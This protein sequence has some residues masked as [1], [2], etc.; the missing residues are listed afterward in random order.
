M[1]VDLVPSESLKRA[2]Q[3]WWLLALVMTAGG[4]LGLL[5]TRLHRPLYESQ[6]VI[7]TSIDYAYSGRLTDTEED[8]IVSTVGDLV[9]SS[10]VME[11][12]LRSAEKRGILLT[13]GEIANRFFK[14]R[15]GFRWELS[16]R[17]GDPRQAQIL[18]GLW[19]ESAMRELVLLRDRSLDWL[20]FQT[21]QL[22]LEHC[23]SQMVVL[24]PAS[25]PC[26][27]DQISV[28]RKNLALNSGEMGDPPPGDWI[29]LSRVSFHLTTT[30]QYPGAPA[31]F[32]QNSSTLVGAMA[33]L[34]LGMGVIVF[35]PPK[36]K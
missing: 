27:F 25:Q 12:V 32:G 8:Q 36:R 24:D 6:A 7:T 9:G 22:D 21:A 23:F 33:G 19:V 5:I 13:P 35:W 14:S 18:A 3:W 31:L 17:D 26:S 34:L 15:Q 10:T 28:I 16:V 20:H 30:A 2:L 29:L 11:D 1:N 4:L